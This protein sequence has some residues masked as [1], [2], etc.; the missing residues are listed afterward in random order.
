MTSPSRHEYAP[1]LALTRVKG[2]GA[3]GCKKLLTQFADPA[4]IFSAS[5]AELKNIDGMTSDSI[6][7]LMSFSDW[8]GV[9]EELRRIAAAGASLVRFTDENYP[10]RLR[11]IADPPPLLYLKG[12]L[13]AADERAVAIV[14]IT[15]RQRLWPARSARFGA[16]PCVPWFYGRERHGPRH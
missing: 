7:G 11:A 2:L 13:R 3:V 9:E 6:D 8:A 5:R 14:G 12:E 4:K 16:R 15:Q 10:A 1:W